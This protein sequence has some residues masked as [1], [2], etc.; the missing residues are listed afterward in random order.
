MRVSRFTEYFLSQSLYMFYGDWRVPLR[1]A[2]RDL[3]A[4]GYA[5]AKVTPLLRG[6]FMPKSKTDR[7]EEAAIIAEIFSQRAPT[8]PAVSP[9][10]QP[11]PTPAPAQA[12][13][14]GVTFDTPPLTRVQVPID[15]R[16]LGQFHSLAR[17]RRRNNKK[18]AQPAE[19]TSPINIRYGPHLSRLLLA[20]YAR[21]VA[22]K[23]I[24]LKLEDKWL[25]TM[26]WGDG[27]ARPRHWKSRLADAMEAAHALRLSNQTG[28]DS[29]LLNA[30]ARAAGGYSITVCPQMLGSLAVAVKADG[31]ID[32]A[33]RRADPTAKVTRRDIQKLKAGDAHYAEGFNRQD[34][35][36][37]VRYL[38]QV[39]AAKPS[40]QAIGRQGGVWNLFLPSALGDP[41]MC[42]KFGPLAMRLWR[43]KTRSRAVENQLVPGWSGTTKIQCRLLDPSVKYVAFAAN[44][45]RRNQQHKLHTDRTGRGYKLQTWAKKLGIGVE[46]FLAD[47]AAA[48]RPL[49]LIVAG[50][51]AAGLW[52]DLDQIRAAD[53]GIRDRLN[54][55]IYT[56][57][58]D[59]VGR[60]C[61]LFG[62]SS[63]SADIPGTATVSVVDEIAEV[64]PII[65]DRGIRAVA[66]AVNVDASNLT[67]ILSR[68]R[69]P[70]AELMARVRAH[71]R[72]TQPLGGTHELFANCREPLDFA[73]VYR[74]KLRWSVIPVEPGTKQAL[75]R[76]I[77]Y[78][79]ML[80]TEQQIRA[81]WTR[82]PDAG[83][84][85]I[86][87]PASGVLAI[88]VDGN[89]AWDVLL[90][91]LGGEPSAPKSAS[92]SAEPYKFHFFFRHPAVPTCA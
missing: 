88:D 10:A 86:L 7:E 43:E 37:V 33:A 15:P 82:W 12:M 57:A 75:V 81:W 49:G 36:G 65:R 60:W 21:A 63:V 42:A 69:K 51:D 76:W 58:D 4:R 80:P 27:A 29:G 74:C 59:I 78:Q 23:T 17:S 48:A 45:G 13:S 50:L 90:H 71:L 22:A 44:G 31:S 32:L 91:R 61:S 47:L 1:A 30:V 25:A 55:R 79:T 14:Q 73:L 3:H 62:W 18:N 20:I 77:P 2:A 39:D 72:G 6:R 34:L 56:R 67:K 66:Q 52:Y 46:A 24:H 53:A 92:G 16:R 35:E 28:P 26:L 19:I 68:K 41:A 83:I 54:V 84:G 38:R 11:A 40:L 85:L 64:A 9:P 8:Q 5:Q 87:G 89:E 70:R